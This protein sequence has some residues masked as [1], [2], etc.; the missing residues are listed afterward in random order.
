MVLG[1][2]PHQSVCL[3]TE[4]HIDI[5]RWVYASNDNAVEAV[6]AQLTFEPGSEVECVSG[7]WI[8]FDSAC[9][10]GSLQIDDWA[11]FEVR[12]PRI[13]VSTSEHEKGELSVIVHRLEC[14]RSGQK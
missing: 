3:E 12:W 10:C 11:Q 7:E 2:E 4:N 5:V 6:L 8:M 14:T 1:D 13:L 9:R